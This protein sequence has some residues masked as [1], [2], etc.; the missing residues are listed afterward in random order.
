M[1]KLALRLKWPALMRFIDA[2][3]GQFIFIGRSHGDESLLILRPVILSLEHDNEIS[4]S[5]K[6]G[7]S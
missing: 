3:A 4:G 6:D 7:I 2:K 5:I 1:L